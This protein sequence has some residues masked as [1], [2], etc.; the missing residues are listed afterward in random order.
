VRSAVFSTVLLLLLMESAP[1]SAEEKTL[2]YQA[3]LHSAESHSLAV[4][5]TP[6]HMLGISA[7][8]GLAI[9]E[10]GRIATVERS[11]QFDF[12]AGAGRFEGYSVWTFDDHS[13]IRSAYAG[14]T[15]PTSHDNAKYAGQYNN[16]SGTG[17]YSGIS[18]EG[19]LNGRRIGAIRDGSEAYERGTLTL[20]SE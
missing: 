13:Q 14:E 6:E 12:I 18:G 7:F 1:V 10:D 15:D 11:A 8:R 3:V 19:T 16:L 20:I 2:N 4:P 5:G 9:F 17:Q